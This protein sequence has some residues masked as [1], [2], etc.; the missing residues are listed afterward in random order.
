MVNSELWVREIKKDG[1]EI[2]EWLEL[3]RLAME[4]GVT[5]EQFKDFLKAETQKTGKVIDIN[6]DYS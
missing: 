6:T 4:S 1:M 5:K 3:A 2:D